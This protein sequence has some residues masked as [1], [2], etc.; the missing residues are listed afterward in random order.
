GGFNDTPD[1]ARRLVELTRGLRCK[2]NLIPWNAVP[3][4]PYRAPTDEAVESFQQI[5]RAA[6]RLALI[7]RSRGQDVF[8]AC[9]QLA[10]LE[11]QPA[12]SA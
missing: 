12:A 9:G 1:D 5:L 4:L 7:R 2:V 8:A 10:L 6:R 11:I 3:E